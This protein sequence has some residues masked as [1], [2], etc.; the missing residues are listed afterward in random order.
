MCFVWVTDMKLSEKNLE[1]FIYT[2]R[3]RWK[4]ENEGFNN[5]KNGIYKIEHLC[6]RHPN[7]MKIHYLITQ[8]SDII[9]QLYRAFNKILNVIKTPIKDVARRIGEFFWGVPIKESDLEYIYRKTA[10][11]LIEVKT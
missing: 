5:Q 10:L 2:G 7:A 3:D 9:M 4:I 1:E 11:R 8:I 6:S